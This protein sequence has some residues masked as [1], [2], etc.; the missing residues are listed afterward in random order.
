MRTGIIKDLPIADYH[1]DFAVS[2]SGL[3]LLLDKTPAHYFYEYRSGKKKAKAPSPD[4][5]F[6]QAFHDALLEPAI[7]K[8]AYIQAPAISKATTEFKAFKKEAAAAG[9]TILDEEDYEAI[10]HMSEAVLSHPTASQYMPANDVS[11]QT[12]VSFFWDDPATGVRCK[13]RPDLLRTASPIL[14]PDLKTCR[15]A[16]YE[17]FR[18]D[19][20]EYG[21][22]IQYASYSSGVDMLLPEESEDFLYICA[23]KEPPYLV[24][25]YRLTPEF[26]AIG[27]ARYRKGLS[28][29]AECERTGIWPG[30]K[31][32]VQE[33]H[34][35]YKATREYDVSNIEDT[36]HAEPEG[37]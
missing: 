23:E 5:I 22:D 9:K 32:S 29:V 10:G 30:Y 37:Y 34:P 17:G 19:I 24:A 16:G 36:D 18:R 12:E 20:Y 14:I 25:V 4:K 21:Y 35:P 2:K 3:K 31:N 27:Y 8:S 11:I 13:A 6:G 26:K 7:F 33:I 1:A 15:S 28:I